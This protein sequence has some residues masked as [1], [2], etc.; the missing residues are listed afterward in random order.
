MHLHTVAVELYLV[1]PAFTGRHPLDRGGAR[2]LNEAGKARLGAVEAKIVPSREERPGH[3]I[4]AYTEAD[5]RRQIDE[6]IASGAARTEDLFVVRR[7]VSSG[8][9]QAVRKRSSSL[10]YSPDFPE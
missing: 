8:L 3:R 6:L 1:D 4:V 9:S 5:E 10:G 7:I 2:R